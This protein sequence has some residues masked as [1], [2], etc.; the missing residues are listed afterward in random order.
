MRRLAASEVQQGL[1]AG[2]DERIAAGACP[3]V[4][5]ENGPTIVTAF[6]LP[7]AGVGDALGVVFIRR[8]VNIVVFDRYGEPIVRVVLGQSLRDGPRAQHTRLLQAQVEMVPRPIVLMEDEHGSVGHAGRIG[9]AGERASTT[10][11]IPSSEAMPNTMRTMPT[12]S[13]SAARSTM[14]AA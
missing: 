3:A 2:V 11:A 5:H 7:P 4:Q 1:P 8:V 9:S 12:R 6:K 10:R 14:G 13:P